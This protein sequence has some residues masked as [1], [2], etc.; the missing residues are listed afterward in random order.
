MK[1]TLFLT[2]RVGNEAGFNDN[3][4]LLESLR[5]ITDQIGT[6][7]ESN[8]WYY[9]TDRMDLYKEDR[10][11]YQEQTIG[12]KEFIL[13]E[14]RQCQGVIQT[15][16]S[17]I[18]RKQGLA[19]ELGL[20][21]IE[22]F[23]RRQ[24]LKCLF[25]VHRNQR[26]YC[27][28]GCNLVW[29]R[30]DWQSQNVERSYH[31]MQLSTE[32][33]NE[34]QL[35]AL[36]CRLS[37]TLRLQFETRTMEMR[38]L[39]ELTSTEEPL[40]E[41]RNKFVTDQDAAGGWLAGLLLDNSTTLVEAM[42]RFLSSPGDAEMLHQMRIRLRILRSMLTFGKDLMQEKDYQTAN[43]TLQEMGR[44][45]S[46]AR[47]LEVLGESVKSVGETELDRLLQEI[48][49]K[50][51]QAYQEVHAFIRNG[52]ATVL[53][54]QFLSCVQPRDR[55]KQEA[56][57]QA[58]V[59]YRTETRDVWLNKL[60]KKSEQFCLTDMERTHRLR[61]QVKKL[62]YV[63]RATAE[64]VKC[65]RALVK[66]LGELQDVLGHIHDRNQQ[67]QMLTRIFRDTPDT[68]GQFEVGFYLGVW[69]SKEEKEREI[70]GEQAQALFKRLRDI[71]I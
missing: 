22:E 41:T 27:L 63:L 9:D 69:A 30:A 13:G 16:E 14:T 25:R 49:E 8:A 1:E 39:H 61:I 67:R 54:T 51:G 24:D 42:G 57:R 19:D 29:Q 20:E 28:G 38:A 58:A 62:R 40:M 32:P 53:L 17:R 68:Q 44:A 36:A 31:E 5:A 48:E 64:K 3:K 47:D 21:D 37:R 7:R 65:E 52:T 18:Q 23:I 4:Y 26:L 71:N 33:G 46:L 11:V 43:E 59:E 10:F 55:W 15:V 60:R 45:A 50:R 6:I 70:L 35:F 66:L 56:W 12:T 34:A 2:Y